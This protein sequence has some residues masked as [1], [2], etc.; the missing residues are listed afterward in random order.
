MQIFKPVTSVPTG[1]DWRIQPYLHLLRQATSLRK[2]TLSMSLFDKREQR[3]F[4]EALAL[5]D[6]VEEVH[7]Q[8]RRHCY[9]R[10]VCRA[11]CETNT[12]SRVR[13]GT[14]GVNE[15]SW[16]S[17]LKRLHIRGA[18][19]VVEATALPGV[20][21][22]CLAQL[23]VLDTLTTLSVNIAADMGKESAEL[24]AQYLQETRLLIEV[25]MSFFPC[26]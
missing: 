3:L 13:I 21:Y 8:D 20:T 24:L 9:S 5:S 4:F 7:I 2:L 16:E 1:S 17:A 10:D 6:V 14:V 26:R 11:I 23:Q 19:I 25:T 22:S 18:C 15:S 12:C